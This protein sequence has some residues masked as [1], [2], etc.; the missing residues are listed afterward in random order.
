MWALRCSAWASLQ[1]W[2]VGF[3]FSNCGMKALGHV[4]SVVMVQVP[5]CMG[6]VVCGMQAL[7]EARELSCCGVSA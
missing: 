6:S 3:L 7:A 4:G 1:L 2:S 5:E